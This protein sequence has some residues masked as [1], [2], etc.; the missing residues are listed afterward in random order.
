VVLVLLMFLGA[1]AFGLTGCPP[2]AEETP[3][4]SLEPPLRAATADPDPEQQVIRVGVAPIFSPV[5]AYEQFAGLTSYLTTVLDQPVE[6][7]QRPTYFEINELVR[8]GDLSCAFVC[9]GAYVLNGEGLDVLVTPVIDGEPR[10]SAVCVVPAL[11]SAQSLD[12]LAGATF[13]VSDPLSFTG[14]AYVARR[15]ADSGTTPDRF[16]GRVLHAEGHDKVLQLVSSGNADGACINSMVHAKLAHVD[17]EMVDRLRVIERSSDF[18]APPVVVSTRAPIAVRER[19]QGAFEG[20]ASTPEGAA[21][22]AELGVE[23]FER[24]R[25]ELYAELGEYLTQSVGDPSP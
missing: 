13:A 8:S 9:S 14:R 6:L 25:A 24:S 16:F 17:P 23:R 2:A 3:F 12:D 15:L 20:M 10:Y 22:L 7:V 5:A 11:S 19:L 18:G 1:L 21:V 4:V